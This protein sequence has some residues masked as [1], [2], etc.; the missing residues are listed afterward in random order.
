MCRHPC[1]QETETGPK[2]RKAVVKDLDIGLAVAVKVIHGKSGDLSGGD[3][4]GRGE[5]AIAVAEEDV[6]KA[7]TA[8]DTGDDEVVEAVAVQI[9]DVEVEHIGE[10]CRIGERARRVDGGDMQIV[11]VLIN[12]CGDEVAGRSLAKNYHFSPAQADGS[13]LTALRVQAGRGGQRRRVYANADRNRSAWAKR[14]CW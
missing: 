13:I 8:D 7:V 5:G 3:L 9:G 4:H 2:T 14:P 11:V 1:R 10:D 6:S 12:E